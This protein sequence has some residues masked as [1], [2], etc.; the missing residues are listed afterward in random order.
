MGLFDNLLGGAE[1]NARLSPQ[2]AFAGILMG[3]SACDGHF[4][5]DETQGLVSALMR[6][7]LFSRFTEKQF[8]QTLDRLHGMIKRAG[9]PALID[10]CIPSL[11]TDLRDTAFANACNIVLADGVAEQAERDF[12]NRLQQL[13]GLD[14]NSA[15]AI[16]QVMVIKNQG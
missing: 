1:D 15:T 8:N 2:E 16:V 7:K 10:R 9:V 12:I 5:D 11:P 3:A 6:M 14:N 13:L 4:A